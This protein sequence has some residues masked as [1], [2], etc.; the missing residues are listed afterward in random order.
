MKMKHENS[1]FDD[2]PD[3]VPSVDYQWKVGDHWNRLRIKARGRI[4]R[5]ERETKHGFILGHDN[6]YSQRKNETLEYRAERPRWTI[7]DAAQANF[8]CDVKQLFGYEFEKPLG[9]RPASVFV[10]SGSDVTIFRPTVVS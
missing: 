10:S 4:R 3:T 1:G 8:T 7:W 5:S 2:A 9:R 6:N